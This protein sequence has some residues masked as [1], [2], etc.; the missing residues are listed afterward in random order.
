MTLTSAFCLCFYQNIQQKEK[1]W[2]KEQTLTEKK[3]HVL[4]TVLCTAGLST[5]STNKQSRLKTSVLRITK[6]SQ[7]IVR[8]RQCFHWEEEFSVLLTWMTLT[9]DK[10]V[11]RSLKE[12]RWVIEKGKN[13][14]WAHSLWGKGVFSLTLQLELIDPQCIYPLFVVPWT[15]YLCH[16][17]KTSV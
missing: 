15:F 9:G 13:N 10:H 2:K 4:Q 11:K 17:G 14:V 6:P 5:A 3:K 12:N 1:D 16:C 8:Y 7:T